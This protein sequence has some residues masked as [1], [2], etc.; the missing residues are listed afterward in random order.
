MWH[1]AKIEGKNPKQ[2][3]NK[4]LRQYRATPHTTTGKP[5]AEVLF[6]RPFRTRLPKFLKPALDQD[7]RQRDEH[8]K[9]I[10]KMNK[11]NKRNVRPHN[12]HTGDTV[13]LLQKQSKSN[14]RYDPT[15]YEVVSVEGT[16][17][18]ATQGE[19]V[20]KRDA[21]NFKKVHLKRPTNYDHMRT[22]FGSHDEDQFNY[23]AAT[24]NLQ[25]Q[26]SVQPPAP[27]QNEPREPPPPILPPGQRGD[28]SSGYQ[29]PN[30]FHDPN[31]NTHLERGQRRRVKPTR[32][33]L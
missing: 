23:D 28:Q 26:A 30:G 18:T 29:Y 20:R 8:A 14:P 10:Q 9:Q 32:Y 27:P 15:P 12:I 25:H 16:Q 5:P 1:I 19:K 4:F 3:V 22:L 24:N 6:N 13:L 17:I 11:D 21:Q 33:E 31:I 2:E 7:F